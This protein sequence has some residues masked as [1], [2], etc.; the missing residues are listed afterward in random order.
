MPHDLSLA[1]DQLLH[2]TVRFQELQIDALDHI[3]RNGWRE[4][5]LYLQATIAGLACMKEQILILR[6]QLHVLQGEDAEEM[7]QLIS[8]LRL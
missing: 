8:R 7:R 6:S 4:N 2:V 3:E 1:K 5:D